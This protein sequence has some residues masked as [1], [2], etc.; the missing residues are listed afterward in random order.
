[1]AKDFCAGEVPVFDN[2]S[3][4]RKQYAAVAA[5][6]NGRVGGEGPIIAACGF[7]R[8]RARPQAGEGPIVI[9]RIIIFLLLLL[10]PPL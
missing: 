4:W 2:S 3:I 9:L 8:A 10:L 7:I 6:P 1:M 5:R